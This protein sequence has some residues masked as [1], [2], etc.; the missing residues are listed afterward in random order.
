MGFNKSGIR[1][2]WLGTQHLLQFV[3]KNLYAIRQ[4]SAKSQHRLSTGCSGHRSLFAA[5]CEPCPSKR[6]WSESRFGRMEPTKA[7]VTP[8]PERANHES[9]APK[10]RIRLPRAASTETVLPFLHSAA[11]KLRRPG[12]VRATTPST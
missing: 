8:A 7:R 11:L 12:Q 2:P 5:K 3:V 4:A 10:L 9:G 6:R 1:S